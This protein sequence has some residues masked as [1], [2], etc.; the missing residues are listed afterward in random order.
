[1]YTKQSSQHLGACSAILRWVDVLEALTN[2]R[3]IRADIG[4][5]VL[6]GS[7]DPESLT[8]LSPDV[9]CRILRFY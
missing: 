9:N 2:F 5:L 3:V 7:M 1:M 4:L 6:T 8:S